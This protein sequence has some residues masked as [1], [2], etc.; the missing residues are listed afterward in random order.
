MIIGCYIVW[1]IFI[2]FF[3]VGGRVWYLVNFYL[4][5][6]CFI[7]DG[8]QTSSCLFQYC[9]LFLYLYGGGWVWA[10]FGN[11]FNIGF[12]CITPFLVGG[13]N[14]FLIFCLDITPFGIDTILKFL[15]NPQKQSHLLLSCLFVYILYILYTFLTY[16][17]LYRVLFYPLYIYMVVVFLT[18]CLSVILLGM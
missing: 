3:Y 12:F 6:N 10:I 13:K 16:M 5:Y 4:V 14:C 11:L 8:S 2:Y 15:I 9:Y 18:N 7:V 1:Y 17:S